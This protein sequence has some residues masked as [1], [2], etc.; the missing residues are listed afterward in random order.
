MSELT[1]TKEKVLEAAS[2][3]S[4]AKATLEVLFPEVFKEEDKNAF[5]KGLNTYHDNMLKDLSKKMFGNVGAIQLS[6]ISARIVGRSDL[7]YRSFVVI[8]EY[9]VNTIKIPRGRTIITI[10]KK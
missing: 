1:I 4:T 7:I 9:D 5:V 6:D 10:F 2:K 3:C 8:S